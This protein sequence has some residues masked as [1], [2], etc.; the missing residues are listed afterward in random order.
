MLSGTLKRNINLFGLTAQIAREVVHQQRG[1]V[2][3]SRGSSLH[4]YLSLR[5]P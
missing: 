4:H 2:T 1:A 5:T 3:E